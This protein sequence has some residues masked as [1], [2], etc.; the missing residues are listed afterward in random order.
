MPCRSICD[1]GDSFTEPY[2]AGHNV[3]NAHAKAVS[4]YRTKYKAEQG[5]MIGITLNCDWAVVS[6]VKYL[7][8]LACVGRGEG[9]IER[10]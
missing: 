5:G 6:Q 8:I 3:L 9:G 10:R 1:E 7:R 2:V 4:T